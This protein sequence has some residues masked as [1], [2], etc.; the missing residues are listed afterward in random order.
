MANMG[1]PRGKC[2]FAV[3]PGC[4]DLQLASHCRL[5]G[6]DLTS[7]LV[8]RHGMQA[9]WQPQKRGSEAAERDAGV[10]GEL[11]GAMGNTFVRV[12]PRPDQ[13][14]DCQ[15]YRRLGREAKPMS[16]VPWSITDQY[17]YGYASPISSSWVSGGKNGGA[18]GGHGGMTPL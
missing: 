15:S 3:I 18:S 14:W 9:D 17:R 10:A 4:R 6:D 1:F 13:S 5:Q 12:K 2:R 16:L 8:Q 11:N 7:S